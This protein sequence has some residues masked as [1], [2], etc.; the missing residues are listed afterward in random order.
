MEQATTI[1]RATRGA[2]S[3]QRLGSALSLTKQSRKF[4]RIGDALWRLILFERAFSEPLTGRDL[5]RYN[6]NHFMAQV[7]R[8]E[9]ISPATGRGFEIFIGQLHVA[10]NT[11]HV[12]ELNKRHCV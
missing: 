2:D 7:A 3:V 12:V 9:K 1:E 11:K 6:S 10:G 5:A 8:M 4:E